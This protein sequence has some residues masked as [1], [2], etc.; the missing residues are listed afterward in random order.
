VFREE[1]LPVIE[2]YDS[3]GKVHKINAMQPI[4]DVFAEI[5]PLFEPYIQDDLLQATVKL[6]Q[7]LDTGNYKI[8]Q[9]YCHPE[10]TV[11]EPQAQ[12]QL[13]EGMDLRNFKFNLGH[14]TDRLSLSQMLCSTVVAPKVTILNSGVG[15]VLYTRLLQ[16]PG[17]PEL[18]YVEAYNETGVWQR[19]KNDN[20]GSDWK[21]VHYHRSVAPTM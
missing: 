8:Y 1:T 4:E 7:G 20:G 21:L 15:L 9:Q 17:H 10:V 3:E 16:K 14:A 12:G 5:E 18:G 11:F 13:V 19:L 6:C 2:Q